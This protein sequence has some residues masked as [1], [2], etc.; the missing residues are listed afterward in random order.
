MELIE[1]CV[2]LLEISQNDIEMENEPF[3]RGM[4]GKVYIGQVA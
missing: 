3:A 1:K 4:F 2:I